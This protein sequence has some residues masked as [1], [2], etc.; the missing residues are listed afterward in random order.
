MQL[1]SLTSME[2]AEIEDEYE[3]VQATIERL[4]EILDS[5]QELLDV[6]KSELREIK[7]T[8]DDERRTG[9]VEDTG[10]VTHEDLIPEE[11]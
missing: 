4:N 8:Y 10:S 11:E 6:I 7:E 2:A 9:F 5:E 3:D 1:G